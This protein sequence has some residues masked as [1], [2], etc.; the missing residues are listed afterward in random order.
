MHE[1]ETIKGVMDR[2]INAVIGDIYG[3][4]FSADSPEKVS[5]HDILN[6]VM[7]LLQA[8]V[9]FIL[10]KQVENEE[11]ETRYIFNKQPF[12][13]K[14]LKKAL[15]KAIEDHKNS[16][17]PIFFQIFNTE[18]LLLALVPKKYIP[19]LDENYDFIPLYDNQQNN[20][21]YD[22]LVYKLENILDGKIYEKRFGNKFLEFLKKALD[23]CNNID[24]EINESFQDK[25]SV[26][27][28]RIEKNEFENKHIE[29][30]NALENNRYGQFYDYGFGGVIDKIYAKCSSSLKLTGMLSDN[31]A[32]P[33]ELSIPNFFIY[34]R[35]YVNA[36]EPNYLRCKKT[37]DYSLRML[38]CSKQEQNIK[39]YLEHLKKESSE[40]EIIK[41]WYITNN[42]TDKNKFSE[43]KELAHDA[44]N[45][46]WEKLDTDNGIN[47]LISIL[48]TPFHKDSY[49][50]ADPVFDGI[51]NF[52]D[53]SIN[54]GLHRAISHRKIKGI[55]FNGLD[56]DIQKEVLRIIFLHYLFIG[57][58]DISLE[59]K[60]D[61]M[62]MLNPLE[63]GSRIIGVIGYVTP[64]PNHLLKSNYINED[65]RL[66]A[67]K[68]FGS[69]W[70]QN[71]H[72]HQD[73]YARLKRNLRSYF[74]Q[75]Y[76]QTLAEIYTVTVKQLVNVN[77]MTGQILED[78]INEKFRLITKFFSYSGIKGTI[79][80]HEKI[81]CEG[82][83]YMLP[84]KDHKHSTTLSKE[85]Y[86]KLEYA[87]KYK[88]RRSSYFPI[89]P[90][91]IKKI[92]HEG[93]DI[94]NNFVDLNEIAVMMTNKFC[95][96]K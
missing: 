63:I 81:S 39:Q 25:N 66:K 88:E 50:I 36:N 29:F 3:V 45:C 83:D 5:L 87:S 85:Y 18:Y 26:S 10:C 42:F 7:L 14:S 41:N 37:Y 46:F 56:E 67:T 27:Y 68:Q 96:Y 64:D 11:I 2:Q 52:R 58:A 86:F 48:K 1:E 79:C 24:V 34:I 90:G 15:Q 35:D 95:H 69:H 93:D 73:T 54:G 89:S 31:K 74:W 60:T 62:V 43:Y 22:N 70:R 23:S 21:V 55:K 71:Y 57:M 9:T 53:P 20:V 61:F 77:N 91:R 92:S 94:T 12:H 84:N 28:N 13:Q 32:K 30:I 17:T 40:K 78:T 76:I 82:F 49:S 72:I 4:F 8:P 75:L 80:K 51:I 59:S 65:D 16:E 19:S 38:I 33:E 47:Y 44:N 6:R